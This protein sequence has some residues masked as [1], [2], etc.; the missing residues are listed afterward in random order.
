[1]QTNYIGHEAFANSGITVLNPSDLPQTKRFVEMGDYIFDGCKNLSYVY[2]FV[3]LLTIIPEGL[4]ANCESLHGTMTFTQPAAN[5]IRKKAFMNTGEIYIIFAITNTIYLDESAFENSK[6]IKIESEPTVLVKISTIGKNCFR[7]C[8]NLGYYADLFETITEIE[9]YSFSG[10]LKI[11]QLNLSNIEFI[12]ANAFQGTPLQTIYFRGNLKNIATV[13][14]SDNKY[15]QKITF[16]SPDCFIDGFHN[17]S[18]SEIEFIRYNTILERAFQNS[19]NLAKITGIGNGNKIS[20][21]AFYNSLL[22]DKITLTFNNKNI[23][24]E[25]YCFS[26]CKVSD[27][28]MNV[29]DSLVLPST[30]FDKCNVLT[31]FQLSYDG[32]FIVPKNFFVGLPLSYFKAQPVNFKGSNLRIGESC[33]EEIKTFPKLASTPSL[34]FRG[35]TVVFDE[36]SFSETKELCDLFVYSTNITICSYAFFRSTL[37]YFINEYE[38]PQEAD[39]YVN[40]YALSESAFTGFYNFSLSVIPITVAQQCAFYLCDKMMDVPMIKERIC[41]YAIYNC[42]NIQAVILNATYLEKCCIFACPSVKTVL[43]GNR[44]QQISFH[45]FESCK[46]VVSLEFEPGQNPLKIDN[47]VFSYMTF[48]KLETLPSRVTYIGHYSFYYCTSLIG[49]LTIPSSVE[50]IGNSAFEGCKSLNG[51]LN[52]AECSHIKIIGSRAFL[53]CV[54]LRGDLIL[55]SSLEEIGSHAFNGCKFSGSLKIPDSV[56]NISDSAFFECTGFTGVLILGS[57]VK[58]IGKHTFAGCSGFDGKIQFWNENETDKVVIDDYAFYGCKNFI[59][60]LHLPSNVVRIG[61]F[62]FYA[63]SSLSGEL[64]LPENLEYIGECAFAACKSFTRYLMIPKSVKYIGPS[65]FLKCSGLTRIYFQSNDVNVSSKAFGSLSVSCFQNLPKNCSG[66]DGASRCYDSDGFDSVAVIPQ[67]QENCSFWLFVKTVVLLISI[68]GPS[69]FIVVFTL[70]SKN[71]I[72][73][74]FDKNSRMQN[75]FEEFIGASIVENEDGTTNTRETTEKIIK[76]VNSFLL[77]ESL[78]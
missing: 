5:R 72:K 44:V 38:N 65:A 12:K 48:T 36:Y 53:G 34:H 70:F 22:S 46:D 23:Q 42:K 27:V 33:F 30:M 67:L 56:E 28:A 64:V 77:V 57:K 39:I 71:V 78:T 10:C 18:V 2:N 49:S 66:K 52:I 58:R 15:L 43:I 26:S 35:E 8:I 75:A 4:F 20:Q 37:M 40:D 51:F 14:F 9:E 50:Y 29:C 6:I 17:T 69:T 1:M 25:D 24:V 19:Y 7:N 55:P 32:N 47:N 41:S 31:K 13:A 45:V 3:S 16:D 59:D 61:S 73:E 54:N 74:Y 68:I 11:T 62:A 76:Y 60:I 21:Y 63:C